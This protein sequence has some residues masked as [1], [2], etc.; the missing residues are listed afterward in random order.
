[1]TDY[2]GENNNAQIM[3]IKTKLS[4]DPQF[5]VFVTHQ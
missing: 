5:M 1:M 4:I 3:L 2:T